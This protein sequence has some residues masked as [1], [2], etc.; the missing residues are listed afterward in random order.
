MNK[1]YFLLIFLIFLVFIPVFYQVG[2]NVIQNASDSILSQNSTDI[3]LFNQTFLI[4]ASQTKHFHELIS[5]NG[6]KN[7]VKLNITCINCTID[8]MVIDKN[9]YNAFSQNLN[10]KPINKFINESSIEST[11]KLGSVVDFYLIFNNTLSS[12]DK[13]IKFECILI[14]Y[15]P[16][17]IPDTS[18]IIIRAFPFIILYIILPFIFLVVILKFFIKKVKPITYLYESIKDKSNPDSNE[19]EKR[20]VNKPIPI[21]LLEKFWFCPIDESRLQQYVPKM[22]LNPFFSISRNNIEIGIKNALTTQKVPKEAEQ[23]TRQLIAKLF[24]EY[25]LEELSLISTKCPACLKYYSC[26]QIY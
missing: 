5:G 14:Q 19:P 26:P 8:F 2:L 17:F 20:Y 15:S 1:K 24:T 16:Y 7:E 13:L 6:I 23:Q 4:N 11:I 9:N 22:A 25:P 18:T 10:Y 21:L 3:P 12:I